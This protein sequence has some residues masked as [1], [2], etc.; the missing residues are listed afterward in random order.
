MSGSR[1]QW[2]QALGKGG[3]DLGSQG[4]HGG[5][6]DHLEVVLIQTPR[7]LQVLPHLHDMCRRLRHDMIIGVSV[8]R[9]VT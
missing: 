8:N 3:R 4:L 7:P 1:T 9:D 5:H 6:V 2:L